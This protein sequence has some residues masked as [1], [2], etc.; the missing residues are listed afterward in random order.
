MRDVEFL[1]QRLNLAESSTHRDQAL[2]VIDIQTKISILG[3]LERI[4]GLLASQSGISNH[5]DS[6]TTRQVVQEHIKRG[7]ILSEK[8]RI[9]DFLL[10]HNGTRFTPEIL[11]DTLE[12]PLKTVMMLLVSM[13]ETAEVKHGLVTI[14]QREV[15]VYWRDSDEQG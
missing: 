8:Q 14:S 11:A 13:S 2:A 9:K 4:A 15:V 5:P 1:K 7:M 6:T 12:I 3:V 10:G